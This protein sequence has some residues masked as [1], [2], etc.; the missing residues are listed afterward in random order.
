MNKVLLSIAG[1]DPSG[2]AGILLDLRIFQKLHYQGTAVI[3][4]HT[5]QSTQKVVRLQQMNPGLI[6]DQYFTLNQDVAIQGIKVGMLGF[7]ENLET[8][9]RILDDS[10]SIPTVID[11]VFQASSGNWL[12][13]REAIPNFMQSIQGRASLLTPN[14]LEASLITGKAV[15]DLTDMERAAKQMFND[16]GLP[17]LVKGGHLADEI[18]DILFDRAQIHAYE[19]VRS[20]H[21]VHGTGCCLSSAILCFLVN[22]HSL[23][24][25]CQK[26]ID[27]THALI[28]TSGAV[29]KGQRLLILPD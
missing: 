8:L 11:P 14:L 29:G 22:G 7:Q 26:A 6:W 18:T 10:S 20:A 3:T 19:N 1:F 27:F 28:E 15:N 21:D 23:A 12:F 4:A 9:E 5:V 17:V 13:P 2:G 24:E 25:A 16:Y